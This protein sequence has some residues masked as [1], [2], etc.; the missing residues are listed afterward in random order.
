[1][2]IYLYEIFQLCLDFRKEN[3]SA[4]HLSTPLFFCWC[5]GPV[6]FYRVLLCSS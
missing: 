4:R 5:S 3:L 2:Y 1:M 6:G